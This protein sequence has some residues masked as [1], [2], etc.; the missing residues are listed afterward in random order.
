MYSTFTLEVFVASM[1]KFC[2]ATGI[3][4]FIVIESIVFGSIVIGLILF[5][6]VVAEA[7]VFFN[8]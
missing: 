6:C 3:I 5:A 8:A 2:K 7:I 1:K 4:R